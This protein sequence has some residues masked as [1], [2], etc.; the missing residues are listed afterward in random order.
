M[1]TPS[2]PLTV[3][4]AQVCRLLGTGMSYAEIG[5]A[6][7]LRPKT[8]EAY[9]HRIALLIPNPDDLKP[10]THVMLWAAHQLWLERHDE[11]AKAS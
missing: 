9:V 11:K 2:R 6:T 7:R 3:V 4:E 8:V 5:E 1:I 10:G